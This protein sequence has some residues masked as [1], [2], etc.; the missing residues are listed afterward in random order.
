MRHRPFVRVFWAIALLLFAGFLSCVHH[1]PLQPRV[2]AG[3]M[4]QAKSL[5]APFG[6]TKTASPEI[7]AEGKKLF[8]GKG[9]CFHCHGM[10][11][12]GD[13]PAA[14]KL[15][16]HPPRDFTDCKWHDSRT[17]GELYWILDHGSI[18]TGMVDFVPHQ[19]TEAQAW[20]VV[21]YLRSFC[22]LK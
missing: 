5:K 12:K 3:K 9:A 19:L 11:G 6:D 20:K 22:T 14:S 1:H 2:P 7:V 8:E 18:G 17:D 21:A 16:P 15:K 4:E 13:G 10:T